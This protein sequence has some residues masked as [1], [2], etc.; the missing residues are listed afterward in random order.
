MLQ[1]GAA[2][3]TRKTRA[4]CRGQIRCHGYLDNVDEG[5]ESPG[6]QH[7]PGP[8]DGGAESVVEQIAVHEV[9]GPG[10]RGHRAAQHVRLAHARQ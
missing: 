8:P 4:E 1:D 5:G 9:Q 2:Y 7:G 6:Q 3:L 10:D